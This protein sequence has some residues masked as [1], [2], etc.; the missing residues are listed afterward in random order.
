MAVDIQTLP[1][2]LRPRYKA[3]R[4]ELHT[5]KHIAEGKKK[6]TVRIPEADCDI[7]DEA[8]DD[9]PG[10]LVMAGFVE[11]AE[12]E[13]EYIEEKTKCTERDLMCEFSMQIVVERHKKTNKV[14]RRRFFLHS[15]DPLFSLIGAYRSNKR[16]GGNTPFFGQAW[17]LCSH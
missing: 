6:G 8:K 7:P 13:K 2:P 4:L 9:D 12:D 1:A 15:N 17:G 5:L 16:I 11:I 3:R 10:T 14:K